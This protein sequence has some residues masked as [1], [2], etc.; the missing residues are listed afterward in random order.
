VTPTQLGQKADLVALE[1]RFRELEAQ[2]DEETWFLSSPPEIINHPAFQAIIALGP[3]VVPLMLRD[4][5]QEPRLWVW[6]LP[7]IT[8]TNPAPGECKVSELSR[9]WVNWGRERG[10]KW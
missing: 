1:K 5:E 2:W 7:Q 3:A 9:I 4:L 8:G 6:A 10:L